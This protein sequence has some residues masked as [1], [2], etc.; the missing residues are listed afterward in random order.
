[1]RFSKLQPTIRREGS[2][3][4]EADL[5]P[6]CEEGGPRKAAVA[7]SGSVLKLTQV[8]E[9][10]SLRRS[11]DPRKRNSAKWFR[12][13]GIRIA[14]SAK[15]LRALELGRPQRIGSSDCLA[16]TQVCAKTKSRRIQTD[17]CP[18]PEG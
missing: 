10:S 13:L 18:M 6:K 5:L 14:F 1:M 9:A 12:N 11:R 17:A 15:G 2:R 3:E 4:G 7:N 16:K 8:G